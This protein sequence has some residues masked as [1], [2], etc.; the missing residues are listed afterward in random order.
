MTMNLGQGG[1]EAPE[2]TRQSLNVAAGS[3]LAQAV[4]A[5]GAVV[6]AILG[7]AGTLTDYMMTIGTI[8]LGAAF[9]MQSGSVA[10]QQFRFLAQARST[11]LMAPARGPG[12]TAAAIAG[13]A[14]VALGILALLGVAPEVLVAAAI[15][16][17]SAALFLD[18]GAVDVPLSYQQ[19]MD[20]L[21]GMTGGPAVA[22]GGG[23][24]LVA[25]G[26]AALGI[27]A[28]IGFAPVT[29]CLVALLA[30]GV[31]V[32]FTGSALGTKIMSSR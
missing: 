7:L 17:F 13:M 16:T 6:L 10:S 3:S 4:A 5:A 22:A 27:L 8:A 32:F 31:A 15:I 23:D 30:L 14:G 25:I 18:S 12:L 19:R 26:G 28:L 24:Q 9:L 11:D 1:A 29:L 20:R 21:E 2:R